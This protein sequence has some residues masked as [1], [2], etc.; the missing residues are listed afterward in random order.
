MAGA[1]ALRGKVLTNE[2]L[3]NVV[4]G[5]VDQLVVTGIGIMANQGLSEFR[6]LKNLLHSDSYKKMS[7]SQR[8]RRLGKE[9][10][11]STALAGVM[12]SI[13]TVSSGGIGVVVGAEMVAVSQLK[14]RIFGTSA[15][16]RE[17]IE[18]TF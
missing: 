10:A 7:P 4:G 13:P 6:D 2:Q 17:V 15:S 3:E 8:E 14:W 12:L 1:M 11:N 16:L 5:L 18:K 9:L